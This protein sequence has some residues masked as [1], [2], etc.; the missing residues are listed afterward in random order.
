MNKLIKHTY[1]IDF[2]NHNII[3]HNHNY[4][5]NLFYYYRHTLLKYF[6]KE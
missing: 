5:N 2:I 3:I 4:Y 6:L 1:L